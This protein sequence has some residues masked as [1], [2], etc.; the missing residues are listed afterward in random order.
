MPLRTI[1]LT[2]LDAPRDV[3]D[4]PAT[5]TAEEFREELRRP[6]AERRGLS[7]V[8]AGMSMTEEDGMWFVESVRR[9]H[10][11]T[12]ASRSRAWANGRDSHCV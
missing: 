4:A 11:A 12:V 5:M 1:D 8:P 10:E 2:E 6:R 7:P 3:A 9:H